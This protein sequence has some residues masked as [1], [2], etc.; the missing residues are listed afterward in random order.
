ME[1]ERVITSAK[2]THIYELASKRPSKNLGLLL[3]PKNIIFN[4]L[5]HLG[6]REIYLSILFFEE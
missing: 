4:F 5:S 2:R 6:F 1:N 3:H